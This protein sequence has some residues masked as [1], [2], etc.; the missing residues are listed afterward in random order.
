MLSFSCN[1]REHVQRAVYKLHRYKCTRFPEALHFSYPTLPFDISNDNLTIFEPPIVRMATQAVLVVVIL[2]LILVT[3]THSIRS[4]RRLSHIPGPPLAGISRLWLLKSILGSRNYLNF[5]EANL[6]YGPLARVGPNR[7]V[8]SDPE[9]WRRVN[10]PRSPYRRSPWFGAFSFQPGVN[11]VFSEQREE[12]HDE[13]RKKLAAGYA[14]KENPGM[15]NEIDERIRD[16]ISLIERKYV[17]TDEEP[18]RQMD[19][20]QIAQFFTLDVISGL[21]F[22]QPF[23]D[24]IVDEDKFDY[25][26]TNE[27]AFPVM[28]SMSELREVRSFLEKSSLMKLLAPSAKDKIGFGKVIGLAKDI[29]AERFGDDKKTKQ[30]MLGSFVSHGL[31]QEEAASEAMLQL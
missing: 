17:S 22:G 14:G 5:F 8:T 30:D 2:T 20:G 16:L 15:E 24:L 18:G 23:G 26:K 19:F 11:N 9:L 4:Y 29:V 12:Q 13:L 27:E 28:V 3:T 10:A 31:G 21:A 6:K 7:L 25:I 1:I